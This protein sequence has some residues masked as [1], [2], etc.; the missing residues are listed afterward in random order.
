M[1]FIRQQNPKIKFNTTL[2]SCVPR[3]AL[4]AATT[5]APPSPKAREMALSSAARRRIPRTLAVLL[6]RLFSVVFAFARSSS[7]SSD[8]LSA[9]SSSG[10]HDLVPRPASLT[11]AIALAVG[12]ARL[13]TRLAG[14]G[15]QRPGLVSALAPAVI[16]GIAVGAVG[17]VAGWSVLR[18]VAC[19]AG[20]L[21][22]SLYSYCWCV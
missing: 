12:G 21:Y 4:A 1:G 6:G 17:V 22:Y 3:T 20:T 16:C 2:P 7:P 13:Q 11:F 14:R 9:S 19:M 15:R 8:S 5:N 10:L 18:T